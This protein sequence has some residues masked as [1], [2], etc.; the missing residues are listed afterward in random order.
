L[1]LEDLKERLAL[2]GPLALLDLLALQVRMV[3]LV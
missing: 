1:G 3:F 2:Q